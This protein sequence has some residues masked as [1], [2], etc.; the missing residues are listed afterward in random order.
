MSK[1]TVETGNL[2]SETPLYGKFQGQSR[3]QD[4]YIEL[5]CENEYISADYSGEIGNAVPSKVY[6][7]HILRFDITPYLNRKTIIVFLN[8][9]LP[10]AQEIVDGYDSEYNGHNNVGVFTDEAEEAITKLEWMCRDIEPE[11]FIY[12]INEIDEYISPIYEDMKSMIED[13]KSP[14][15]IAEWVMEE[16]G[17]DGYLN[18][19]T[20]VDF[21]V[22]D[23]EKYI[24]N[25]VE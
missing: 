23:V 4:A 6:H 16:I 9:I 19:T 15:E 20:F 10:I 17:E 13:G 8:S 21:D 2:N 22:D 12:G 24:E 14:R 5:D 1:V 7:R 3:H 25:N 18:S 11:I